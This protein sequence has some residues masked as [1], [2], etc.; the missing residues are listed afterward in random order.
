[1]ARGGREADGWVTWEVSFYQWF[2]DT[3]DLGF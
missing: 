1:M 2:V 3:R